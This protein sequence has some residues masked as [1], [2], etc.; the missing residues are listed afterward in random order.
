MHIAIIGNGISGIS[1][2]RWIRK[3]SDHRIT[4]ISSESEHFYSRT[5]LMYIY[6]G[7][8]RYQDTKPYEDHFWKKNRINL[9]KDHVNSIDYN[10]KQLTMSSGHQV[11]YDKLVLAL[12]SKSNKFGWPGQDLQGVS[13]LYSL[14]DLENMEAHSEGLNRAVIVGGGLIGIEM[15]EMFHSR[16]IP[17]TILIREDSY[18]NNVLPAEE[19][20]MITRHIRH[21]H[22]D[23]R[24]GVNLQEIIDDGHGK[25]SAV[26][27]KE[28]GERIDCGYVGL[29][30]G[31]SPNIG[32]I[33]GGPIETD[34]GIL[35]DDHLQTSVS[36]IYALGDCAQ[37]RDPKPGRRGIEAIWYTGRMMGETCAYN[38]C[39]QEVSYDPGIWFN[40]A[41]FLDIEYQVYGSVPARPDENLGTVYWEHPDGDKSI[42]LMYHLGDE[43]IAGFNLM[44]VRFRHEVCE[45]WIAA[46]TPLEEVVKHLELA[47]FDPEF[48]HRHERDFVT[49]YN[50]QTGKQIELKSSRGLDKV[51]AFLRS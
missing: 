18:W 47:H 13:G 33:K 15:A 30:P 40:S 48:Y 3:L 29:T 21:H 32:W 24:T 22:I 12:G 25:A 45:K 5:A 7:H 1:C 39:G 27:V 46:Q 9:L 20:A 44:G 26:I 50:Q 49:S 2:A 6:M 14:Q 17:V 51:F 34:R 41:K 37:I 28:T 16:H 10:E 42:R 19:S 8:M 38:L 43:T 35:V 31:V 11:H 23:L 4:V 36:D